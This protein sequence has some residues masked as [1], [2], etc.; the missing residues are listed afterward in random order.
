MANIAVLEFFL[1]AVV[2]KWNSSRFTAGKFDFS[3]TLIFSG[4]GA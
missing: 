1:V 2:R 3:G 4:D